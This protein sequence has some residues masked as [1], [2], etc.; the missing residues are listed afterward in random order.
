MDYKS[1]LSSLQL[2]SLNIL[3]MD[4]K[5]FGYNGKREA[6]TVMWDTVV[7]IASHV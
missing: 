6:A 7:Y 4:R 2:L 1:E 5:S 3:P